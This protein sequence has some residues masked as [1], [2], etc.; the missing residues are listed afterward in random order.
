MKNFY[1]LTPP[2]QA[3]RLQQLADAALVRWGIRALAI[4]PV[5]MRENAVFRVDAAGGERFALR[6]HRCGYHSDAALRS[7]L[8]WMQALARAGIDVPVVV[9]SR[10]GALFEVVACEAVPEAR[11]IDL[12]EWIEGRP[13]GAAGEALDLEA[14]RLQQVF[15]AL[16]E[17]CARVHNQA[18]GWAPPSGFV[19]HAWD[20]DGLTG[21][22]PLWGRFW[23]L[24]ALDSA[25]RALIGEAR[26]RVRAALQRQPRSA[27]GYSMIHA[28]LT[29]DNVMLAEGRPRL[30]DF[31][32]A[33]FG[34][35]VF[36]LATA[37][38]FHIREPYYADARAALVAGYRAHRPLED[39][40]LATLPLF[41]A[42]RGFTYLGWVHTRYETE[43][44]REL[45]PLL[46][47]LACH[48]AA[49]YLER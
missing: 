20:S 19:R 47:D 34:W 41:L 38:Y 31:D 26:A 9:A 13:L 3:A 1:A 24:P 30:L 44:A 33:G 15:G 25:Q 5:K 43:T 23:E 17:L 4:T 18:S 45:T 32:D 8:Q 7:E 16:G 27:D 14:G 46:V 22:Q 6:I 10:A 48:A 28:D 12:F 29:P 37:L 39:A 2:E 40:V 21:E 35:H 49:Q 11:Q 42:A 36:E